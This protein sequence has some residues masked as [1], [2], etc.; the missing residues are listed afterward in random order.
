MTDEIRFSAVLSSML[1][2]NASRALVLLAVTFSADRGS[3]WS[4]EFT[5][6]P[7]S[8]AR[9]TEDETLA[10]LR[11]LVRDGYLRRD[12]RD[13]GCRYRLLFDDAGKRRAEC[14]LYPSEQTED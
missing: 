2:L 4:D 9:L 8:A 1:D 5:A 14:E 3:G 7:A 10:V 11:E 13:V 6:D 12:V